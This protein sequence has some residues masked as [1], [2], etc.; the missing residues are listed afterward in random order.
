M[1]RAGNTRRAK[2]IVVVLTVAVLAAL[3]AVSAGASS[4]GARTAGTLTFDPASVPAGGDSFALKL[5]TGGHAAVPTWTVD[6]NGP[7][8]SASLT[9]V[10]SDTTSVTTSVTAG[11]ISSPGFATVTVSDGT[12]TW[13]GTN[14]VIAAPTPVLAFIS[15]T[16]TPAGSPDFSLTAIGSKF[17]SG[18]TV[19]WAGEPLATTLVSSTVV[20][21]TVPAESV[22]AAGTVSVTVRN[23]DSG[24]PVSTAQTFTITQPAGPVLASIEP[25]G[26]ANGVG[27]VSF[28][29]S[30]INMN[31]VGSS[32]TVT[33]QSSGS[34]VSTAT[35]STV[36][37]ITV[38]GSFNLASPTVAPGKYDVVLAGSGK[39]GKL[40]GAFTVT[41]P[42][43]TGVV[44]AYGVNSNAAASFALGGTSLNGLGTPVV[45]LKT[46]AG[47][48]V[49]TAVNLTPS[50]E[51]TSMTGSFNLS[52]PFVPA[53]TYDVVLT[54]GGGSAAVK[55][56]A[57][58]TVNNPNPTI[59][60]ISPATVYAGSKQP[61]LTLTVRGTGF[62]P[63]AGSAAG[64]RIMVG[65]RV[66]TDTT[67]F[68]SATQV[69][70]VLLASDI[71]SATA[72]PI[73]V[74]NATPG[75][76]TST[77]ASL[78]VATDTQRPVTTLS[79]ADDLWHNANVVLSVTATDTQSGVQ[80]TEYTIDGGSTATLTGS[81]ITI[82]ADSA[83]QGE[84][85]VAAWSV[86]WCGNT[87][88]PG[89]SA[90]VKIDVTG[91][92]TTAT[93]PSTVKTGTKVSF[94][95]KASDVTPK[96]SFTLKIRYKKTNKSART[97]TVG[98]KTSNA[99][100]T[101]KIDP[102][103]AKGTYIYLVYATDQAGNKQSKLGQKTF[104][105][106]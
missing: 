35:V 74:V 42:T 15:P 68:G 94:G 43:L 85:D 39:S 4:P 26:A 1:V 81:T 88:T 58:Y 84:N 56:P 96:C 50:P 8:G 33:L 103:L 59:T 18:A 99:D 34:S 36:T 37:T 98:S 25:T 76:G 75:G 17:V 7:T 100:H 11:L 6:W 9:V 101:Y 5:T 45:T 32:P 30:G 3:A 65:T 67:T 47:S 61:N 104:T 16:S 46:S 82:T 2:V 77:P 41:G 53:G 64:T 52:S 83:H 105:V 97:Y 73:K 66:A 69:S 106:K 29:L 71:A 55:L 93:V 63:V 22:T 60:S 80:K 91:P 12:G 44:P 13:T 27:S 86:D 49:A 57:A 51:G 19:L 102:K 90:V 21:A 48:V 54:Y 38:T 28:T 79:G 70:T 62:V 87:E 14:F 31:S 95:Y 10:A 24:T 20:T 89:A 40:T 23:G 72:L 92:K 78:T